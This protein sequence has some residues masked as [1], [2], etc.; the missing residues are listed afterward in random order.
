MANYCT[1]AQVRLY[2]GLTVTD[3]SDSALADYLEP[4]TKAV[5]N[6]ISAE[7]L[8]ETLS[9]D[10]EGTSFWTEKPHIADIDG[11]FTIDAS[12]VTVYGWTDADD[13]STKT[14]LT[15]SSVVALEGRINVSAAPGATYEVVTGNY[16][17]Y[18][19]SVDDDLI[20]QATALYAGYLYTFT[21]WVW[22]PTTYKVGSV[23]MRNISPVYD[24][25]HREYVRTLYKIQRKNYSISNTGKNQKSLTDMDK[26]WK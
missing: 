6:Q 20:T 23:Y 12:D 17:H 9:G 1:A 2:T 8:W 25:I 21:K 4:A 16:R 26:E 15:V 3:A 5:I 14:E 13:A 7:R 10:M 11:D 18:Q 22:I 19:N 24:R